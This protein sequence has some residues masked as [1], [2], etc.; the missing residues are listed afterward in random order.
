MLQVLSTLVS[1]S[2]AP[3]VSSADEVTEDDEEDEE[4]DMIV[5]QVKHT[6]GYVEQSIVMLN[7]K[8][9]VA[10]FVDVVEHGA[11]QTTSTTFSGT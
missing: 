3:A 6:D 1:G 9:F 2:V 10:F 8:D 5:D 7:E 11:E 4:E